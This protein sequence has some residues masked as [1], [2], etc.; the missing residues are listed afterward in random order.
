[1]TIAHLESPGT[2]ADPEL[3]AQ[4][5]SPFA[6]TYREAREKFL[7]AVDAA[8]LDAQSQVHPLLGRDGEILAVDVCRA[9]SVDAQSLLIISSGCHGVEG[10]CGSGIQ[11]DLLGDTCFLSS[12]RQA[13]VAVLFVHALNP[14]GFSWWR[15]TT[16][17]NID[18]N[19]NFHDFRQPLPANPG[20]DEIAH[21]IVPKT[22]PPSA[23]VE[24][25]LAAYV[26]QRGL[27]ALQTAIS[28]GQHRRPQ[29][30]FYGGV[31]PC[32]SH[33]TVR[34]LL[35]DQASRCRHLGWID[36]HTGLGPSGV[37]ERIACCRSDDTAA[38]ARARTWWGAGVTSI[39]DGSSSSALLTGMMWSA[40][41][42]ECA[43]AEYTG[44]A[45][46]FG[47][48]P[49]LEVMQSLRADQWLE[50]HPEIGAA[51]SESIK[52][53]TRDAFYVDSEEWKAAVLA[54][55][56]VVAELGVM[57]LKR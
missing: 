36:L 55:G 31:D 32:W 25:A 26:K 38:L 22:W 10:F 52:R 57:G 30:L 41:Y 51:Q 45:L 19:R 35:R 15:R 18:L 16:H 9:G 12:A 17:E 48:L 14:W 54:Q 28:A 2:G 21:L 40:A 34:H 5:E 39:D 50:N 20:Y 4:P 11:V 6:Q 43:P 53:A 44:I 24:A 27:R 1:M 49:L 23:E 8:G 7:A 37:G 3:P 13:G 33:L 46:E 56:R 29:G 42:E 47:T